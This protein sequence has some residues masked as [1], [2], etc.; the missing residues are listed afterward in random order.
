MEQKIKQKKAILTGKAVQDN[1]SF[2]S[3]GGF[4]PERDQ[5][6]FEMKQN[7]N[8]FLVGFRDILIVLKMMEELKEIPEIGN[9]WWGEVINQYEITT[10][11]E[12]SSAEI[13]PD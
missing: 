7:D 6:Y 10:S 13:M 1:E 11:A 2:L 9:K 3:E 4:V 8:T 12:N 5:W